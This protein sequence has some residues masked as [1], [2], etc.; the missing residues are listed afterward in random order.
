MSRSFV[1]IIEKGHGVDAIRLLRLA[2]VLGIPLPELL[3]VTTPAFG[4]PVGGLA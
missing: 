1:S 3:G 2:G 4:R